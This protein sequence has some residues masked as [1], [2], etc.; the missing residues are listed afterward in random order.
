M[1][2]GIDLGTTRTVVA[3][4]DRG[5][6]PVLGFEDA[7]GDPHEH[8]PSVVALHDG[9]LV[10]GWAALAA[11]EEGAPLVRSFKRMLSRAD[12]TAET[13][14]RFGD[15]TRTLGEALAAFA[16]HVVEQIDAPDDLQVVLGVPANAHSA[17]RLLTLDAFARTGADVIALVNE[18]SAGAFEFTHRHPRTVT[19]RRTRVVVYDL[20]GGTFDGSLV[21]VAGT[22][23]TVERSIG[24]ARL[25]GDDFDEVLARLALAKAGRRL[26]DVDA[27]EAVRALEASRIVKE[28]LAPQSRRMLIE[29]DDQDVTVGVDD[30]Y[31]AATPL[32]ERSIDALRP[33]LGGGADVGQGADGDSRADAGPRS[34]DGIAVDGTTVGPP[35]ADAAD[36]AGIYLVGG[37]SSLPLVGR[38]LRAEF[39][40]RVH[41]SPYPSAS[42]AIGLAIAADPDSGYRLRDRL[43]RGIGVFREAR[44]GAEVTFDPLVAPGAAPADDGSLSVIRRY[45]A[46]HNVGWFRFVEFAAADAHGEATGDLTALAE[47]VVPFD[48]ALRDGRDLTTVPVERRDGG[49]MV[50]ETVSV[51]ANGIATIRVALDDGY[52]AERSVG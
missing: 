50:E 43:A 24:V 48:P 17:Q 2:A 46:A 14:V 6:Y 32:V 35:A 36:L 37:A 41:R 47:I 9:R 21:D 40:R 12:A 29:L 13:P 23:H 33:L 34:D 4:V 19:S 27:Y 52:V 42:T 22:E 51:D 25:G 26:E 30:F 28:R 39:G 38:T 5:N 8:I 31:A 18:P 49:P 45:R 20:G 16:A 10:C 7:L 1:R 44:S 11:G 3:A 15:R